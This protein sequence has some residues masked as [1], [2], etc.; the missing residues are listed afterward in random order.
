MEFLDFIVAINTLQAALLI[1]GILFLIIEIFNPGFGVPGAI[2]LILVI[3][4]IIITADTFMDALVLLIIIIVILG[5]ALIFAL[6]SASKGRLSK[7]MV[8]QASLSKEDGFSSTEDM[9]YFLN[10]KGIALS[11]LR[12]A[13]TGEFEG[14]KLDIVTEGD[15][16]EANTK[17]EIIEVVGRRIIVRALQE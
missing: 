1:L 12:P 3:A 16:I 15:F 9:T 17:I 4:G 11:T 2:G 13:G 5:I 14:V 10:K 7:T 6:R 8:L